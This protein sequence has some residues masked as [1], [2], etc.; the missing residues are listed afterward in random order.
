MVALIAGVAGVMVALVAEVEA[1]VCE[2]AAR[3]GAARRPSPPSGLPGGRPLQSV[4]PIKKTG[5]FRD[6]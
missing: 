4:T 2:V 5:L 3:T 6:G 1:M